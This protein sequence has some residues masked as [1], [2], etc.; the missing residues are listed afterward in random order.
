LNSYGYSPHKLSQY[1]IWIE[2]I[3]RAA[4]APN[5][6]P[7]IISITAS[8]ANDMRSTI[9]AIQALRSKGP[10]FAHI[11]IEFNTSCPNIRGSAPSGY[12]FANL[13]PLLSVLAGAWRADDSL[14][15]GLKLPPYVY[16]AQ[17]AEVLETLRQ[18]SIMGADGRARNP[19]AYVACTNTLGNA[20]LFGEQ[21]EPATGEREFAVPTA[22]GGIAGDALHSLALGNVY[23][24]AQL[25]KAE[26]SASGLKNLVIIGIG[27]VTSAEGAARMR[28]AGASI[29]GSATLFG[30]EGVRAFKIISGEH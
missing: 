11:G 18:F 20:L 16:A 10:A 3:L 6:K 8:H 5:P 12:A 24:F 23:S 27:G 7:F 21:V 25:V 28:K 26:D 9:D 29:V 30:K 22:L 4:P 13:I 17:F 2:S 14:T 1:W 19:I 15:I